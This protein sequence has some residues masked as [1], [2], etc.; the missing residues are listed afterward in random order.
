MTTLLDAPEFAAA[1]DALSMTLERAEQARRGRLKF[2]QDAL[3]RTEDELE[4][5]K[6]QALELPTDIARYRA[7]IARLEA[8]TGGDILREAMQ[9]QPEAQS[10]APADEPFVRGLPPE[11]LRK[12]WREWESHE[13]TVVRFVGDQCETNNGTE[14][15]GEPSEWIDIKLRPHGATRAHVEALAQQA[16]SAK[17]HACPRCDEGMRDVEITGNV[18]WFRRDS[19]NAGTCLRAAAVNADGAIVVDDEGHM[20]WQY[21]FRHPAVPPLSEWCD[22]SGKG[23]AE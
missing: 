13:R 4:R 5:V 9:P 2:L 18:W 7:E 15:I 17:P 16:Q 1:K 3:N 11:A 12:V 23:G 6:K 21:R 19:I 8:T 22:G 14:D 10:A 20:T